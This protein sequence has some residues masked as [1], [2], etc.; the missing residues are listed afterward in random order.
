VDDLL[1]YAPTCETDA[2]TSTTRVSAELVKR[3]A[4]YDSALADFRA[5]IAPPVEKDSATPGTVASP[6]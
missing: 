5:A 6:R 3:I 2:R 4:A 1:K